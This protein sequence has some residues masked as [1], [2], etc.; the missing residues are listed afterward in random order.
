MELHLGHM[1]AFAGIFV[2]PLYW[3]ICRVQEYAECM[4]AGA[5]EDGISGSKYSAYLFAVEQGDQ[6]I[7]DAKLPPFERWRD[8]SVHSFELFGR[9]SP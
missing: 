8:H 6:L 1:A 9:V 4:R 7:G 5:E 2:Q 3:F